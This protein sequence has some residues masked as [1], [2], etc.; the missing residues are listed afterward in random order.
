MTLCTSFMTCRACNWVRAQL[1]YELATS[2]KKEHRAISWL[3]R[4]QVHSVCMTVANTAEADLLIERI[5]K[6]V[7]GPK[8]RSLGVTESGQITVRYSTD[9][10]EVAATVRAACDTWSVERERTDVAVYE[11]SH[12]NAK[13]VERVTNDYMSLYRNTDRLI[14]MG[15]AGAQ[16]LSHWIWWT[17]RHRSISRSKK[18][19]PWPTREQAREAAREKKDDKGGPEYEGQKIT[20]KLVH[21]RTGFV[22]AEQEDY[23]FTIDQAI[24]HAAM[25]TAFHSVLA[26][27]PV[28][29][30]TG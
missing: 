2:E 19:L 3:A 12:N 24:R 21:V 7:K 8:L 23:P 13:G 18:A 28:Q 29:A 22:I 4:P 30:H 1:D 20:W 26:N 25:S 5:T 6:R 16:G 9:D 17:Q 14:R 10:E 11:T 15:E 27:N